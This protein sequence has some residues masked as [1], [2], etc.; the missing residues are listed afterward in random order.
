M[1]VIIQ[2]LHFDANEELKGFINEKLNALSLLNDKI[3][4][5]NV[6][7]KLENASNTENRICEIRLAIPGN[8]LFSKKQC[9]TFEEAST[10]VT[11]ALKS[12]LRTLSSKQNKV[13]R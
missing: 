12:Q 1:N 9:K 13:V 8:D 6:V 11:D 10:Q 3:E 4:S 7:L 2:S 5:A